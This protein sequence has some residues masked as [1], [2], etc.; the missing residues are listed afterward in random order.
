MPLTPDALSSP[1]RPL[2]VGPLCLL[3]PFMMRK[4][5]LILKAASD[6]CASEIAHLR[7]IA[8]MF[9]IEHCTITMKNRDDFDRQIVNCAGP[10][11]YVYL[12]AHANTEYFGESDGSIAIKWPLLANAFCWFQCLTP[13]AVLL[14]G[15]CR[16]GLKKVAVSLFCECTSIDY[17]CGPRWTVTGADLSAGFHVFV[18]N[19][20]VRREQPSVAVSRASAATGYDFFC[21]DRVEMQDELNELCPEQGI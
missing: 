18:Y 7:T 20:E 13:G 9:G 12:A 14:L 19:M 10:Y 21:H 3:V 4:R 8:E 1:S 11:D 17:V 6:V 15:C 2:I 5:L 16:G